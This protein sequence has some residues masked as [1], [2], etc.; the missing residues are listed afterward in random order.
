MTG[1]HNY[2]LPN[3]Y[4]YYYS[5]YPLYAQPQQG[6]VCPKCGRVHAPF[7]TMCFYCAPATVTSQAYGK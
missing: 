1:D 7:I 4:N 5:P 2:Y 6:W 3:Q